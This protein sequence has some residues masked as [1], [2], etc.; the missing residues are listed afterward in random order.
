M[1][2]HRTMNTVIHA[3]VRR[4]L[5]RFDG[6]LRSFPSGSERR[7]HQLKSA[8]DNLSY[9]LHHH[10]EDEE[11]YFWPALRGLGAD[12]SLVGDLHGEHAVMLRALQGADSALAALAGD[13]SADNA[14]EAAAAVTQ[15]DGV[16][17]DHLV[18][19]ERDLEPL[20]AQHRGSPQMKAAAA[21]A[22]RSHDEGGGVFFAW[23]SDGIDTD[24]AAVLRRE[25]PAA[26]LF[27]LTRLGR[28]GYQRRIASAWS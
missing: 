18:H 3:A 15:L 5:R 22:R 26:V 2:D 7:A 4:D 8:W 9:Q 6:A 1:T 23:L 28:R 10:H 11:N 16:V 27:M 12:E 14:A 17:Q 21:S 25:V 20:A 19:E 13:P 24:T